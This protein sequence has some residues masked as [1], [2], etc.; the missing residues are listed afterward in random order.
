MSLFFGK[1]RV[2]FFGLSP[3][4]GIVKEPSLIFPSDV[5]NNCTPSR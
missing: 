5:E 2:Y 1:Y 3:A 4:C